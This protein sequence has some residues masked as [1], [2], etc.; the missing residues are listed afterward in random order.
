MTQSS[1][2][3]LLLIHEVFFVILVFLAVFVGLGWSY[4]WV[5]WSQETVRLT[6]MSRVTES[7]GRFFMHDLKSIRKKDKILNSSNLEDLTASLKKRLAQLNELRRLS[8]NR[9]EDYAVQRLQVISGYALDFL[10]NYRKKSS[11][12]GER[13]FDLRPESDDVRYSSQKNMFFQNCS[14]P[15][16]SYQGGLACYALEMQRDFHGALL[17]LRGIIGK[18]LFVQERTKKKWGRSVPFALL[19]LV[20]FALILLF[21]S[22]V[23]LRREFLLPLQMIVTGSEAL[24]KGRSKKRLPEIGAEEMR[25]LAAEIN[26]IADVLERSRGE[27]KSNERQAALAKLVPVVAHNVKNPLAS[28]RANAQLLG[29]KVSAEELNESR[30]AII[31]TVDKLTRWVNSLVSYLHP[32]KLRFSNIDLREAVEGA[33]TLLGEP[34]LPKALTIVYENWKNPVEVFADEDLMEQAIFCLLSNAVDASPIGGIINI[35]F[36]LDADRVK[37]Y[38]KD[39]GEGF[40]FEYRPTELQPGPSTKEYGT[41]L[42]LPIAQ[43]ICD[44]HEFTLVFES[45]SSVGTRVLITV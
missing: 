30:N 32:L 12:Q 41:G 18:Q 16:V 23:R 43:K 27:Q 9:G 19:L 15:G 45:S 7:L 3:R 38:I 11:K 42:G 25:L 44:A 13:K 37:L 28:I 20:V 17:S 26:I 10:V 4:F 29:E 1:L 33:V 22:R 24:L 5:K 6:E 14:K 40:P 2:R 21:I 35:G 34:D 39:T 31:S 8:K 36:I